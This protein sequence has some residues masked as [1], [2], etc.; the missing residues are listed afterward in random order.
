MLIMDGVLTRKKCSSDE[1]M[2]TREISIYHAE[3][4]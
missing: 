2:L 3:I 1:E 4:Y